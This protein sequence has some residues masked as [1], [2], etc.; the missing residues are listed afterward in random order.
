[1]NAAFLDVSLHPQMVVL[2]T[3]AGVLGGQIRRRRGRRL[4]VGPPRRPRRLRPVL[5]HPSPQDRLGVHSN[6]GGS[7]NLWSSEHLEDKRAAVKL[8][9]AS[10]L[11][12]SRSEGFRTADLSLPF[13]LLEAAKPQE[14]PVWRAM[15]NETENYI[16]SMVL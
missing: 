15:L 9:F 4:R 11:R 7:W 16:F 2:T 3:Q 12:Y 5:H 14:R 13:K 6:E 8:T 10:A 1:M